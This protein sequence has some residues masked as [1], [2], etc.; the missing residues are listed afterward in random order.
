MAQ[1]HDGWAEAL[2]ITDSGT[3]RRWD[4]V[5]LD[6]TN[7]EDSENE[8]LVGTNPQS[9]NRAHGRFWRTYDLLLQLA[10][11]WSVQPGC[12]KVVSVGG[13]FVVEPQ[14]ISV[15][16]FRTRT[17]KRI[18]AVIY[19]V[20]HSISMGRRILIEDPQYVG[21]GATLSLVVGP[22]AGAIRAFGSKAA[23]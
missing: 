10:R 3:L 14:N 5:E 23:N 8:Q 4:S 21:I 6:Q 18:S 16:P 19:Q 17:R 12:T 15:A 2:Q 22:W 9:V 11:S 1:Q 20:A 7:G 13:D